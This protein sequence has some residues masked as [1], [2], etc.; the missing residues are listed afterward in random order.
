MTKQPLLLAPGFSHSWR[1][2]TWVRWEGAGVR[3]S[4]PG[5]ATQGAHEGPAL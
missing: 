1:G 2:P 4:A 3:A 5:P